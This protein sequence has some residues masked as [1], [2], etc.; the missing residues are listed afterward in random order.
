MHIRLIL[1]LLRKW[2]PFVAIDRVCTKPYTIQSERPEE[3]NV[4]LKPGDLLNIPYVAL[5]RN[6]LFY[7]NPERFD[8][9]RFNEENKSKLVT[10]TYMP[11]GTGP[12]ICIGSRFAIVELK[13][14]LFKLLL[15]FEKYYHLIE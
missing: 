1:E 6:P 12:R 5:H 8:P 14:L 2:P 3:V 11:F 15:N 10:F 9:E 7:P 4:H 13:S